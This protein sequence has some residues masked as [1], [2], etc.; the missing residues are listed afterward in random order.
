MLTILGPAKTIDSSPHNITKKNT[1]PE[2]LDQAELLV[3]LIRLYSVEDLK[4]L[5]NVSD[6]LAL[7]NF[8]RYAAW[9]TAYTSSE[10]QQAIL[11]FSGEVFN[12]LQARTLKE[13]DLVFAQDHVRLLSGLYGVLRPLDLI[14]SYRL[15]MG[16]KMKNIRGRNLYEF[17]K[18]IIPQE[19]VRTT[20]AQ[21]TKILINL[22]SNE[23]FRS[24]SPNAFP[25]TVITPVFKES[26]GKGFRNV[27]VYAKKAR[28]MMLRFIIRNRINNPE[29]LKA[30]DEE[31][32]YYNSEISNQ[33]EW[34]FCR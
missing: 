4:K 31:G 8:E 17:W 21:E 24:I 13:N 5:M 2:Y 28:G 16:T 20:S 7:L 10:G 27:T 22:A 34:V 3:A 18:D 30:F 26:D 9:R 14:L 19:I 29:Y 32:Y 23:Y 33:K 15:E 1:F 6:K 11:A 25:H 12:G